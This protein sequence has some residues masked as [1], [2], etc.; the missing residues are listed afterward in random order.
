MLKI[1]EVNGCLAKVVLETSEAREHLA[2]NNFKET[3]LQAEAINAKVNAIKAEHKSDQP[4][5]FTR[6]DG[7]IS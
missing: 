2:E 4:L 3:G 6:T 1:A 7:T 5:M